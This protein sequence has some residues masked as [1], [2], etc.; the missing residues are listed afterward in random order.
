MQLTF[1][2]AATD[3]TNYLT[4]QNRPYS[5]IDIFNNLHKKYGKT[6][7]VQEKPCFVLILFCVNQNC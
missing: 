2:V 3:I 1:V 5:A 7:S 6:V 4:K